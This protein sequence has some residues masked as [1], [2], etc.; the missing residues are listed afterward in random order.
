MKIFWKPLKALACVQSLDILYWLPLIFSSSLN[1]TEIRALRSSARVITI[2]ASLA[3]TADIPGY[4]LVALAIAR[5]PVAH[6]RARLVWPVSA[7]CHA[8]SDALSGPRYCDTQ[9]IGDRETAE[10]EGKVDL[11]DSNPLPRGGRGVLPFRRSA[12]VAGLCRL[13]RLKR[14]RSPARFLR[15]GGAYLCLPWHPF[16][17]SE[18]AKLIYW[19]IVW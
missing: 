8:Q 17:L 18:F 1:L 9:P 2:L 11:G 5:H 19:R 10:V 13:S 3:L 6:D 4:L 14:W 16:R 15:E 7:G 12:Q